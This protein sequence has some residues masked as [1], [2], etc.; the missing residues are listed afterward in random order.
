MVCCPQTKEWLYFGKMKRF[1]LLLLLLYADC[2]IAQSK[3]RIQHLNVENGLSQSSVYSIIQDS[4]GYIWMA[5]G[6]GLNRY[7]GK[8]FI[9]YKSKLNDSAT[10]RL[11]DRNIN[12]G[13]WEDAFHNLWFNAD[14]GIYCLNRRKGTFHIALSKN[15][16]W[17]S[18]G[19]AGTDGTKM[20]MA[21]APKGVYCI[22]AATRNK[23]LYPFTDPA[24]LDRKH[25]D[26]IKRAANLPHGIWMVDMKGILFFDKK[27][28]KERRV[29][30]KREINSLFVLKDGKLV[31]TMA[32]SICLYNEQSGLTEEIVIKVPGKETAQWNSIAEDT[33]RGD[34][35][36]ADA[37]G[38]TICKL[39]IATRQTELIKFQDNNINQLF[40]D[41]SQNL[42]VGTDGGGV[43]KLDIKPPKFQSYVP[44]NIL[45]GSFMVKSIYRDKLGAIW[46]GVHDRGVI[47]YD[48]DKKEA[49]TLPIGI[50]TEGVNTANLMT[51]TSGGFMLSIDDRITWW[52]TASW[53]IIKQLTIPRETQTAGAPYVIHSMLEWKKGKF[54]VGGNFGVYPLTIDNGK[55]AHH[56]YLAYFSNQIG[57][58]VY[59]LYKSEEGNIYIGKRNGF[60]KITMINDSTPKVLGGGF[61]G[62]PIRHFYKSN[63]TPILWLATEQGLVAFNETTGK[64]KVFDES[65]GIANSFIYAILPQNDSTLWVSTNNGI[66]NVAVS[67]GPDIKA[68]FHNYTSKDGLQSNEFNT[69]AYFKCNDGTLM[70]GGIAGIN[71]F[72]PDDIAHNPYKPIPAIAGIY[73]NDTLVTSDTSMYMKELCL[74]YNRNTLSFSLRALEYTSPDQNVFAYM[75]E[76]LDKEWVY[77]ANDKVRY[78]NLA[79]GNYRFLLKVRNN[80]TLWNETPL[81]LVVSISP[82]YWQTWWFRLGLLIT[83]ILTTVVIAQYFIQQKI[84]SKTREL[85]KQNA[86]NMERI[87]IS[88]D[89]H[90]DI[91]SGLSKISL[92]SEMANRKINAN[93]AAGKDI[94]H[95]TAIS[96]EL[97]DNMRDL[98]WVLNPENTT[99]DNLISRMREYCSDYLDGVN[100]A[101]ILVFP[102]NVPD[103]NIAREV[104]RNIFSTVKEAVNNCVKH[105]HA[106]EIKITLYLTEQELTMTIADNGAGF[107]LKE[108]RAGGNGLHNMKQRIESIGGKYS[109]VTA[110][111]AGTS[112]HFV[113]P[114]N[115]LNQ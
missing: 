105:G 68:K 2:C 113:V 98:I 91:G 94:A 14:K 70:F 17:S 51:D 111:G 6:D 39:N 55:I 74:P 67:Y 56:R 41:R 32:N 31:F 65:S 78:S 47:K 99:L 29:L 8:E 108:I 63:T 28:L 73:I 97:V 50:V 5:T 75:L 34:V 48:P 37:N 19:L 23:Q 87:R 86:L 11:R 15:E 45:G 13:M 21:A 115:R 62:L 9:A 33:I 12:S 24:L 58:W 85:E 93:E 83:L 54:L 38:S 36:I 89:V 66:S 44:G 104:Q 95:I 49:Y 57:G 59:N 42:W 72:K 69:G 40:I 3:L 10:G 26:I 79:P 114:I 30:H 88:K 7:D 106:T 92:H 77:T 112:V 110:I 102:D 107:V 71:W 100:V 80:E 18:S 84:K 25:F 16:A 20:W 4:Y 43:Y 22:D 53:K 46:M 61:D 101:G 76:G 64:Y 81:E 35:Y 109:I 27:K 90:D 52:D 1:L 82:P 96:K 103:M 60:S